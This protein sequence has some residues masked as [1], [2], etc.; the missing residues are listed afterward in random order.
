MNSLRNRFNNWC[1]WV[2]LTIMTVVALLGLSV[3][4]SGCAL[5]TSE[6]DRVHLTLDVDEDY[7][8]HGSV[9]VDGGKSWNKGG[10]FVLPR[11]DK[12]IIRFKATRAD[13]VMFRGCNRS[14]A[15]E[16]KGDEFQFVMIPN[17]VESRRVDCWLDVKAFDFKRQMHNYYFIAFEREGFELPFQTICDGYT[18][19]RTGIGACQAGVGQH[20]K[21]KTAVKSKLFR[22]DKCPFKFQWEVGTDFEFRPEEPGDYVCGFKE[23][24][25]PHRLGL[26]HIKVWSK[27]IIP[28]G[29]E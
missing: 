29:S 25:A 27:E 3:A 20:P 12:H 1:D 5:L 23:V 13:Y 16:N 26:V 8:Y 11:K 14:R 15:L 17:E 19:N 9:S 22:G 28:R 2:G 18:R 10:V 24:E 21:I 7:K 6:S 4:L